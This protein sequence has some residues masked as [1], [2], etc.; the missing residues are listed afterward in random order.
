MHRKPKQYQNIRVWN[1]ERC[2]ED[3]ARRWWLMS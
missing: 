3:P 2:I 1:R